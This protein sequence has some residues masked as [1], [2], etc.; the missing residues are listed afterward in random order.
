MRLF[1]TASI[2]YY[3]ITFI[4]TSCPN[5]YFSKLYGLIGWKLGIRKIQWNLNNSGQKN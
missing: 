4:D 3:V 5:G 1:P 2:K